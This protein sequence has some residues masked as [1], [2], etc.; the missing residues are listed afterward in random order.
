MSRS[1]W[2]PLTAPD[3]WR[4]ALAGLPHGFTHLPEYSAAAAEVSG[5]AAGLWFWEGSAGRAAC[6]LVRR[7]APGGSFDLATPIGFGGF[8][9]VGDVGG[10]A[11]EGLEASWTRYWREAGA[12]S[13]Y[14][15]FSPWQDVAGWRAGLPGFRALL[16]ES[17]ECWMWDLRPEVDA[18]AS[19]MSP[20][21]RQL[22]HKWQRDSAGTCWDA[23]RLRTAFDRL[24]AQFV[25]RRGIGAAYRFTPAA[26]D[27][28][29]DAPGV[30]WVGALDARGDVEA[31][32]VFLWHGR[33]A[34]SFL[35]AATPAGRWHSRGLYWQGALRLRALGVEW[36]NLGG[37]VTDGDELARFKQRLGATPRRT[38][39]LQQVLDT[40]AYARACAS[41]GVAPATS[42]RFPPWL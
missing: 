12:C 7:T 28:L 39:A 26:M 35:N 13:A 27:A 36:L 42:A 31:V 10:G 41:A 19:A 8:A 9:Y 33:F 20:K 25:E 23:V 14:V 3:R 22:L 29:G 5:H 16:R 24:Y 1:Q 11:P 34:D 17:R 6:P 30:L 4:A 37:G 38:L 21:H 32:T 18:L 40:E 2:I 15:Q